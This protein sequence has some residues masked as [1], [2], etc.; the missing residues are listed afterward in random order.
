M[1]ISDP[2]TAYCLDEAC[3]Y[4]AQEL[5]GGGVIVERTH[6]S[7]PSDLYRKYEKYE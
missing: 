6:Y 7:K 3:A 1:G 4:I 5:E 2:Y